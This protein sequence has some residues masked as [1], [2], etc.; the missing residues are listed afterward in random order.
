MAD[1]RSATGTAASDG[2]WPLTITTLNDGS[3]I[4]IDPD[5]VKSLGDVPWDAIRRGFLW[6][7][8][9]FMTGQ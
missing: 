3:R 9:T 8:K 1:D 2:F 4:E 7:K 5:R 6:V